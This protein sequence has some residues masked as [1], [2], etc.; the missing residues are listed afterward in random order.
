MFK[1]ISIPN[2]FLSIQSLAALS[3]WVDIFLIFSI[4]AFLWGSSP[5]EIALI[6]SLFGIP[7]LF[8]G[9]FIGAYIDR[10]DPMRLMLAGSLI[11][12]L[13]T[14][15]IM[16][17]PNFTFFAT[18][19][20]LKG[21]ANTLYWPASTVVANHIIKEN[22][23]S[24]YFSSQSV[25]EQFLKI[26]TPLL[27]GGL[28]LFISSTIVFLVS[29]TATLAC[30]FFLQ[31]LR[32]RTVINHTGKQRT[33]TSLLND[34]S[35]GFALFSR[36]NTN[37]LMSIVVSVGMSLSLALYDPHLAAFF[38]REGFAVGMFSLA[39]S[40]TAIGAA[41]GG[42]MVRFLLSEAGAFVL[43]RIGTSV[44]FLSLCIV[45]SI[46]VIDMAWFNQGTIALIWFINGLGY[47]LFIIGAILNLQNLCPQSLIGRLSTSVRSVQMLCVVTGPILGA[48]L[49]N[50][51]HHKL[52]FL[53]ACLCTLLLSLLILL[54]NDK[55]AAANAQ[56]LATH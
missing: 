49:I 22:E 51:I 27:I 31:Q 32:N 4:P 15:I 17:S 36:L 21:L 25:I 29:A 10:S 9:P 7:S 12:T 46:I 19:V 14:L 35:S 13:L 24:H 1:T 23:R 44:F 28:I 11:R 26:I 37:L 53:I 50:H 34:L 45:S 33:V 3:Q 30:F 40:S 55:K 48:W 18:L 41:A 52:P 38:N 20:L 16:F 43:M 6:A 47:E 8:L 39:V 42:L 56:A 54:W 5:K 2:H